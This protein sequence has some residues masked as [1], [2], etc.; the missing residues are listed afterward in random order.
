MIGDKGK[1]NTDVLKSNAVADKGNERIYSKYR[2]TIPNT[3]YIVFYNGQSSEMNGDCMKL[4]LSDAFE[5]PD[6]SGEF[7]W[8]ATMININAGHSKEIME[9]CRV[10]EEY[11]IFIQRVREYNKNTKN[12]TEAVNCAVDTCIRDNI[13][14]DI[15]EKQKKEV[16]DVVLT[17]FDEEKFEAMI[18]EEEREEGRKEGR[19]EGLQEG[20]LRA[21][22][23]L[24]SDGIISME[25]AGKRL[26][27]TAQEFQEAIQSLKLTAAK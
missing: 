20:R 18:R 25:E 15:L 5:E 13:L 7:E 9:K 12:L 19:K 4:K 26:E 8:T 2:V 16:I 11:S 6:D 1:D 14:K 27:M 3:R 21:L 10:L 23:E 17:E 22:F 24:V